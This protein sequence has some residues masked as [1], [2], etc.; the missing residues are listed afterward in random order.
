MAETIVF[1]IELFLSII[2]ISVISIKFL[3]GKLLIKRILGLLCLFPLPTYFILISNNLYLIISTCIS[4]LY[5]LV[6]ITNIDWKK[7]L[8]ITVLYQA[9]SVALTSS[10][11]MI[12]RCFVSNERINYLVDLA[13]NILMVLCLILI[14]KRYIHNRIKNILLFT[15]LGFKVYIIVSLYFLSFSSMIISFLP[16]TS[17]Y[18]TWYSLLIF[19]FV[20]ILIVVAVI[21]P[22][23]ISNNISK[24]YYKKMND[25][26][27]AQIKSQSN[28]YKKQLENNIELRRFKHDQKNLLI[29]LQSYLENNEIES[30][31]KYIGNLNDYLKKTEGCN[32]GNYILD[33]LLD[34]KRSRAEKKNISIDFSGSLNQTCVDD[35][36]LC[37]IFGNA[38]DNAIEAC[39]KIDCNIHKSISIMLKQQKHL[40]SILI[41][42][43]VIE[44]PMIENNMIVT[45]KTDNINHGFGLYSIKKTVKKYNGDFNISC[46]DN[47]F[48]M[49]IC[50][51]V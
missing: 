31:K 40:V 43:P 44:V 42:N 19:V 12:V 25:V 41:N 2:G 48:S 5:S 15:N 16:Q 6:A 49:K 3:D 29:V 38:L 24:N 28:Y 26:E 21:F 46:S 4:Y 47:L 20:A 36:D 10:A 51:S 37:I 11:I 35:L 50:L 27:Y 9:V 22:I 34:D 14:P 33:A 13:V 30:A 8:Y 23:L 18:N 7:R 1:F 32:T 39:E 17:S 45:S